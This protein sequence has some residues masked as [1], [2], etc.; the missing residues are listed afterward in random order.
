M[1]P[2]VT[3]GD[4]WNASHRFYPVDFDGSQPALAHFWQ[5]DIP[6]I[7][8][9]FDFGPQS[10]PHAN[11]NPLQPRGFTI[12]NEAFAVS[13]I[14]CTQVTPKRVAVVVA[15]G[16]DD[17]IQNDAREMGVLLGNLG[18]TVTSF[19]SETDSVTDVQQGIQQAAQG[20]GPCDEFFLYV[21]SHTELV[22]D[23][24]DGRPDRTPIRLDYGSGHDTQGKWSILPRHPA[25]LSLT[26]GLQ[27]IFAG[28]V[29]IMLDLL[30]WSRRLLDS[31]G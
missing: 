1:S 29:N 23:N 5:L 6:P 9:G 7:E 10:V 19:N 11:L 15:S 22:D 25:S 12:R 20:L 26:A 14:D 27:T 18:F 17:E 13:S 21:S 4:R 8:D 28:R 24:Y 30:C 2:F 16:A 31:P 3:L